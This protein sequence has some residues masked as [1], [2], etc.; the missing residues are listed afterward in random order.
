MKLL[1]LGSEDLASKLSISVKQL[2]LFGFCIVLLL[3]KFIVVPIVEWQ[4]EIKENIDFYSLQLR[5]EVE[6]ERNKKAI[7]QAL[8]DTEDSA[9]RLSPYFFKDITS[10]QAQ[11]QLTKKIEQAVKER[12]MEL[13]SKGSTELVENELYHT[14]EFRF[15]VQGYAKQLQEFLF[16]VEQQQPL[17][18]VQEV[19]VRS[20]RS[21]SYTTMRIRVHYFLL[22]PDEVA[23]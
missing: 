20:V 1:S 15:E 12:N 9:A 13:V 19:S 7:Q 10:S 2:K 18:V 5:D 4:A 3:I 14:L 16:W 6:I 8:I 21:T 17:A 23:S 22:K 11:I